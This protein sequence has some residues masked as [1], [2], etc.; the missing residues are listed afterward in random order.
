MLQKM[1]YLLCSVAMMDE[2]E[3]NVEEKKICKEAKAEFNSALSIIYFAEET[4]NQ[5]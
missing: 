1:M 2:F 5:D 3:I 4:S